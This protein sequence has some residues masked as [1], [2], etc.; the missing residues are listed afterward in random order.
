ML[1]YRTSCRSNKISI[2]SW[3]Q[4]AIL[5]WSRPFQLMQCK[6]Y[7]SSSSMMKDEKRIRQEL[8]F[9]L[10]TLDGRYRSICVRLLL[11]VFCWL[12]WLFHGVFGCLNDEKWLTTC[13][14]SVQMPLK[15]VW[16]K[17][18]HTTRTVYKVSKP[19]SSVY[20]ILKNEKQRKTM[21]FAKCR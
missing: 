21:D 11:F 9:F 4:S 15:N 6:H 13:F 3:Q 10:N 1:F 14:D 12:L 20:S 7:C 18:P 8:F 19:F 5:Y 17:G 16:T 2:L